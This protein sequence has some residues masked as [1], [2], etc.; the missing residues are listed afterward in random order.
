MTDE[1]LFD[2]IDGLHAYDDGA[3]DSGIRDEALRQRVIEELRADAASVP[4]SLVGP[5]LMRFVRTHY[6]LEPYTLEDVAGFI[7]WLAER[8]ELD[9]Q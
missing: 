3:T 6:Y 5:R 1:E 8:M 9:I 4:N 2:A 7:E